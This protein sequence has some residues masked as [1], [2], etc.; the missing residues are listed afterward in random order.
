[1]QIALRQ[2]E[3]AAADAEVAMPDREVLPD[4]VEEVVEDLGWNIISG[5][6]RGQRRVVATGA[7]VED[8]ALDCAGKG[9]GEGVAE[10]EV[11]VSRLLPSLLPYAAVGGVEEAVEVPLRQPHGLPRLVGDLP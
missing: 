11:G 7:G 1:M 3:Q 2:T 10:G 4:R 8:V 6:C 5:Q 9:G